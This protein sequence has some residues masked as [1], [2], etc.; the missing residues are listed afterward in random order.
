MFTAVSSSCAEVIY[1]CSLLQQVVGST[2]SPSLWQISETSS[3]GTILLKCHPTSFHSSA[4]S[5]FSVLTDVR[6]FYPVAAIKLYLSPTSPS[7]FCP[8][9]LL[10]HVH[11]SLPNFSTKTHCCIYTFRSSGS[12]LLSAIS[13]S[14]AMKRTKKKVW[15]VI[16]SKVSLK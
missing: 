16:K 14:S 1:S 5:V 15:K 11:K 13:F 8:S 7:T 12:H 2:V 3:S 9:L 4:C 10:S 6:T